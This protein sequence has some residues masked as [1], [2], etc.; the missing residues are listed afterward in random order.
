[1]KHHFLFV[2]ILLSIGSINTVAADESLPDPQTLIDEMSNASRD[3]NYDGVFVYR[4]KKQIDTMRI[5]HKSSGKGVYERLISLT[6]NAR[7]VIRDKDQVKCFFP[8]TK[9]VVVDKS[10]LGKLISTY[11][12]SPI[13]SISEFYSFELA[14]E[15]RIAGM[16]TWIVNIRPKDKYRYGYQIWIEKKSR[17]LLKSEVKTRWYRCYFP[18][19]VIVSFKTDVLNIAI[20]G[21]VF[22]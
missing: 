3:L 13:K 14:G 6:G 4:H 8:E 21:K 5:I 2:F 11:L 16:E 22:S 15:D 20:P 17:L 12:P 18:L 19:F 9:T 1:M 7:E 10:R